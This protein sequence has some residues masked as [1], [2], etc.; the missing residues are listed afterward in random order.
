MTGTENAIFRCKAIL[1][2]SFSGKNTHGREIFDV[3]R[4]K[5]EFQFPIKTVL[6]YVLELSGRDIKNQVQ[7]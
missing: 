2:S 7:R 3:L 1:K 6:R 4:I 5:G